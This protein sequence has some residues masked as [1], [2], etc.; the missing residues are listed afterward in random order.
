MRPHPIT[1]V[2]PSLPRASSISS[3]GR[4][5]S[6]PTSSTPTD[7]DVYRV[8]LKANFLA[9][10]VDP[11]WPDP[12]NAST[13]RLIDSNGI[14]LAAIGRSQ[15]PD[16]Q[17]VHEQSGPRIPSAPWRPAI[18]S[19]LRSSTRPASLR[20]R[21]PP[22]RTRPRPSEPIAARRWTA[23]C[24][25]GSTATSSRLRSDR[26]WLCPHRQLDADGQRGRRP[27]GLTTSVFRLTDN[28]TL[29]LRSALGDI[30]DRRGHHAP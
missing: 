10:D 16:R 19:S 5:R 8:E 4:A 30:P 7:V 20:L 18:T 24:S 23:R 29:T 3:P 2:T 6:S 15:E 12:L 13:L 25:R 17:R 26:I 14:Q 1:R 11:A 21:A 27:H 28:S 22:N 9:I